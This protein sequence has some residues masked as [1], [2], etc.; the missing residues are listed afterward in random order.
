MTIPP[1]AETLVCWQQQHGRNTLPWQ[2]SITPYRVWVSEI[3]LQQTQVSTVIDY[4]NRFIKQFPDVTSLANADVDQVLA[5]WSGLGYYSRG[6]NLH[7]SA[8]IIRDQWDGQFPN[9]SDDLISLPGIGRSTAGA[10][11]S[12]SMSKPT[13]ILDGNVKR[14]LAR[15]HQI[16][17]DVYNTKTLKQLWLLAEHH[18]CQKNPAIYTQAIMDL[19]ATICSRSKPKCDQCPISQDCLAKRH[20]LTAE[21]PA[22]RIK[23][24]IPTRSVIQ[25]IIRNQQGQILMYKR[26]PAGIWGGLW[27]FIECPTESDIASVL[28]NDLSLT[29]IKRKTLPLLQHQ[30]SH[31]KLK[32]TPIIIEASEIK[33]SILNDDSNLSWQPIDRIATLGIAKPTKTLL[34]HLDRLLTEK[35]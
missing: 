26:P 1:I 22:K 28:N 16:E 31:F 20:D 3:M 23:K 35:P 15:L 4:F 10:I 11:L 6:R 7:K 18:T 2:L 34:E 24:A 8:Q 30:F 29:E 5:L 27:C 19:G 25:L 9:N 12:I 32:I 17:G 21:I 33:R 13:A 14:V